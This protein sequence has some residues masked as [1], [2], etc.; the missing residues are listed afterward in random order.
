MGENISLFSGYNSAENRTTNYC[1]LVLKTLYEDNPKYL[2]EV[3][4]ELLGG[5]VDDLV[6][7]NFRQQEKKKSSVPDGLITQKPFTI[8]IETKS[9]DWF[10]ASQ[11][12]AHLEALHAEFPG[13]RILIALGNFDNLAADRFDG[14]EKVCADKY[15]N[16]IAFAHVSFEELLSACEHLA[17]LSK[18]LT[19]MLSDY[20]QYLTGQGLLSSWERI[21]DVVNCAVGAPEVIEDNF[22]RCP[23]T[24]GAYS[25]SRAKFFGMYRNKKVERVAVIEAVVDLDSPEAAKVKWKNVKG[26]DSDFIRSAREKHQKWGGDEYPKRVFLLGPFKE[27]AFYKGTKG[28]MFGSKQYFDVGAL[29]ATDAK[30]LAAKLCDKN[31]PKDTWIV[32]KKEADA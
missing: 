10:Y 2:G 31:W 15:R 9:W 27:T 20:R 23:A 11:L 21:L 32:S 6:G 30:D 25:H 13:I 26:H 28:G 22:Y 4:V 8:Y 14:I 12:E 3:L 19:D 17:G 7:V 29:E 18:N 1:L 24:G 5:K 16:S